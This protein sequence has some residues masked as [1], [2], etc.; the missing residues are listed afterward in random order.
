M[1]GDSQGPRLRCVQVR[2]DKTPILTFGGYRALAKEESIAMTPDGEARPTADESFDSW[3]VSLFVPWFD[4]ADEP[5]V[6]WALL[7]RWCRKAQE[8][9][10]RRNPR[11]Y[12]DRLF[13]DE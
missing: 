8:E 12:F 6:Q 1:P 9:I 10:L 13:R 2:F 11:A 5:Q 7:S 3:T 4:D